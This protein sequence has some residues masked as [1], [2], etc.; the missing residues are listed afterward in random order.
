MSRLF[1]AVVLSLALAP[2][3][4]QLDRI[5]NQDAKAGLK[6]AL[7]KGSQVAVASLGRPDGFLGNNAVKIQLPDSL[8]RYEK[9]MRQVGM[10]KYA[11]EL[12]VTMNRAAEAAVPEARALFVDAVKKMS[13]QDA[14][15]ILTGGDTAGTEYFKRTTSE[16][17]RAK[18]VP[19]VSQATK[20]VQVAEKYNEF[21][22]KGAKFGLL[23]KEDA[24]LDG[25]ITQK[26]LDGLFYMVG[27]EE[28]RIR[29]NPVQ[30]GNDLLKRV[31]GAI[32]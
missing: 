6:A 9:L 26:A 19:I 13:V 27:E 28:K 30:A 15:A 21:A 2:A 12:V 8:K 1:V 17:L 23:K 7:E 31:F 32:R 5:T 14:K 25:Y 18:F 11:D 4:A 22:G 29:A 3:G 20:R 10:G 16:P 24:N